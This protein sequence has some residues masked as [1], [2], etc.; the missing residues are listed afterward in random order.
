MIVLGSEYSFIEF[1]TVLY[2]YN[3]RY[4]FFLKSDEEEQGLVDWIISS[5]VDFDFVNKEGEQ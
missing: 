1:Y 2:V 3:E 5:S 4:L